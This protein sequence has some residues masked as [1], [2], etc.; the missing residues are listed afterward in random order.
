MHP[1]ARPILVDVDTQHD[2]MR[3]TG[4]LYVPGAEAPA[5]Q[6]GR[7]VLSWPWTQ[8]LLPRVRPMSSAS[9]RAASPRS[10]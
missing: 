8:E 7:R 2:F 6:P 9:G 1:F 10:G 3:P 5:D 4:A